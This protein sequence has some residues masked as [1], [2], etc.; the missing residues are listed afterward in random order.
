MP[1]VFQHSTLYKRMSAH[2]AR[3]AVRR[4]T[5]GRVATHHAMVILSLTGPVD[6]QRLVIFLDCDPIVFA[7]AGQSKRV[8]PLLQQPLQPSSVLLQLT[9]CTVPSLRIHQTLITVYVS[10]KCRLQLSC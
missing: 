1:N 3:A 7:K 5:A 6:Q 9:I 4:R 10:G 2:I 8:S